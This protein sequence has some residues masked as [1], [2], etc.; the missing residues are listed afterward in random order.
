M[1]DVIRESAP[2]CLGA[3]AASG[4]LTEEIKARPQQA[5]L[6]VDRVRDC[7]R[8]WLFLSI[9]SAGIVSLKGSSEWSEARVD[10]E[11]TD[12]LLG[13][14]FSSPVGSRIPAPMNGF[15]VCCCFLVLVTGTLIEHCVEPNHK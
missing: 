14:S 4:I 10:R 7:P 12:P 2:P 3:V 11:I 13:S 1:P 8:S 9:H 6:F 15:N 5:M